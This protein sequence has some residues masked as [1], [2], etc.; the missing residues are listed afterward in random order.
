MNGVMQLSWET[1][2]VRGYQASPYRYVAIG[3][4]GTCA[5]LAPLCVPESVPNERFRNAAVARGKYALGD[6][7]SLGAEYRFYFDNWGVHSQTIAPQFNWVMTEHATLNLSYRYYT[8]SEARFYQPR[9]L[10]P[11][12]KLDYVT[13]DRELSAMYSQRVGLGVERAFELGEEGNTVLLA[14]LRTGV[15]HF[16]YLAFVGLESVTAYEG[17]FLLSLDFR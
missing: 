16:R 17:T 6:H 12:Q 9:Y 8:Q 7:V 13:R 5:S 10:D 15:T 14:A 1:T 4:Q 11:M 2:R 3:G